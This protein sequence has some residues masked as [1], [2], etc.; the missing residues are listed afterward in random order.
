MGALHE[1]HVSL[2]RQAREHSG[3]VV[4][5]I[6]VNP[7]Q[8]DD[9]DDLRNY[10]RTLERDTDL[11]AQEGC[12]VLFRPFEEEV[13]HDRIAPDIDINGLGS[14]MEGRYRPGHFKGVVM[15]LERLFDIVQPD[16]AF[17]GQ[18]DYQQL[19]I[20]RSMVE[21]LGL[22][23]DI[24]GC[25]TVRSGNGLALSSR[26]QHLSEEETRKATRLYQ[27]LKAVRERSAEEPLPHLKAWAEQE[28]ARDRSIDLEYFEI[29]DGV[30]LEP[31]R[32]IGGR[33]STVAF[34]AATVGRVRLIDNMV[35]DR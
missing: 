19:V 31:V 8:F 10:P 13:Y 5:S 15:V 12:D 6:F 25:P 18:K 33:N 22:S 20:V 9:P 14:V 23:V 7:E 24:I 28:L 34:V 11:L 35:L 30:T 21:Q 32:E 16:M 2:I 26:N 4:C 1:G 29:A 3:L 17:F 27:I